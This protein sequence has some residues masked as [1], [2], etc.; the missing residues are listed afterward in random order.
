MG[1]CKANRL[2]VA[3]SEVINA[4]SHGKMAFMIA[5]AEIDKAG[6]LVVPKKLRDS[7]H[8][9]AGTRVTLELKNGEIHLAPATKPRGLYWKN[10][11]PVFEM[12]RP[13]PH[14]HVNWVE[15]DREDRADELS[16]R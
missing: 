11:V 7:L 6:R 14:D 8:L 13:L 10:G 2:A 12:G 1:I 4:I 3:G 15:Q 9:V 5:T 16:S